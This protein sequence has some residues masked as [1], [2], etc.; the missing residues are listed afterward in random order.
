[1]YH[2]GS[3]LLDALFKKNR[4]FPD[5]SLLTSALK[6]KM[7]NSFLHIGMFWD[8]SLLDHPETKTS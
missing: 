1:M 2:F 6:Q 8:S 3:D 7:T 4:L 5:L